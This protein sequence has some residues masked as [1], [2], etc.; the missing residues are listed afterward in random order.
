MEKRDPFDFWYAVNNTELRQLPARH[1]ETFGA[2]VLNYHLVAELMDTVGQVR[3]REG[4]MVANKPQIITPQAYSQTAL[5]GFGEEAE[6]YVD[7]LKEHE[8]DIRILQYGYSL[9][10]EAFSEHIVSD[11]LENVVA[12]VEGEVK[13]GGDPFSAIV[14]GVD[15]PWD[16]CLVRLF[17]EIIQASASSNIRDLQKHD[18]FSQD[19]GVLRSVRNEIEDGF[20]AANKDPALINQLGDQLRQHELFDQYEDRFFSL[21]KSHRKE[22]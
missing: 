15:D 11:T 6:K 1:L 20:K 8:K 19:G 9:K 14:V 2:T 4:R 12:R 10:Q 16:V 18:L 3:V 13:E 22:S 7:W 5:E 21:V 17:W